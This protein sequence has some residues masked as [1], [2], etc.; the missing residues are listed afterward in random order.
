MFDQIPLPFLGLALF[1]AMMLMHAAGFALRTRLA[2]R[3]PVNAAKTG[4][5]GYV[6]SG[7]FG[8]LALLLAFSL[9][10]ALA[11]YEDRRELAVEEANAIGTMASRMQLVEASARMA[12]MD[13]L[14][15]YTKLRVEVGRETDERSYETKSDRAEQAGTRFGNGLLAY[16]SNRP[17]NPSDALMVSAYNSMMDAASARRAAR[18]VHLPGEV[19]ALLVLC[20]LAGAGT[21]GHSIGGS[22]SRHLLASGLFFML[23]SAAFVTILDLDRPR[24]GAIIVSQEGMERLA[25]QTP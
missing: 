15:E 4:D 21:L 10:L 24:S 22:G 2:K 5:E 19:L 1:L 9:S 25:R 12:M 17:G 16:V 13:D 8:L 7:M 20:C 6:L 3:N 23:L 18:Q 11:R 14:T